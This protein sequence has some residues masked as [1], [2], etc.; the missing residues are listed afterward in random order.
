M[1]TILLPSR[2]LTQAIEASEIDYMSDRMAAIQGRKGNPEGVETRRFGKAVAFY[3]RTMPWPSFNTVKGLT[4]Q[5]V[6]VIE[7]I[8]AFYRARERKAQ[9]EVLPSLAEPTLLKRLADH[10]LYQ[11]GFHSSLYIVPKPSLEAK[12]KDDS[13]VIRELRE[14]QFELYATIHCRGT[15]LPDSGI[16][17]VAE[18][19]RVLYRRPGWKFYVAYVGGEPAAVG[20]LYMKDRAASLTFA[21]TLP[22]YRN[23]GLQR[24]LLG[25]RI[26]I[27][28]EH[29]CELAFGQCS[30]LSQSH[31]NMERVGMRLGYVR[32]SWTER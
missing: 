32:A 10:G 1:T 8:L 21:A 17:H 30:F 15:E 19:N 4:A 6:D 20:V 5:E 12:D 27:A 13:I 9:F 7:P 31:R 26:E 16:P 11:S 2:E 28:Y 14:D 23:R 22:E 24:R 3:S 25:H 29:R 18:N